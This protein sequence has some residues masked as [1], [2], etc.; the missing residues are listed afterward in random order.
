VTPLGIVDTPAHIAN[1][2]A[3]KSASQ[4]YQLATFKYAP[5]VNKI[6]AAAEVSYADARAQPMSSGDAS[7]A[8]AYMNEFRDRAKF[9]KNPNIPRWAQKTRAATFVWTLGA[10]ASSAINALMQVPMIGI[11]ELSGRYGLR[12]AARELGFASRLV[13]NAGN[14]SRH[15]GYGPDGLVVRD[16]TG[17]DYAGSIANYFEVS[18]AGSYR[19][20]TDDAAP[21]ILQNEAIADKIADLD[22]LVEMMATNGMLTHSQSQEMLGVNDLRDWIGTVNKYAGL[23]MHFAER[24][25][26]QTMAVAAYTL[27]IATIRD[28]G[29]T[30]TATQKRN[31]ALKAVETTEMVN[32]SIGAASAPRAFQSG[33]GSVVGLYKRFG[34]S[35]AR[36]ITNSVMGSLA[37]ID[38]SAP[39]EQ[40]ENARKE[41]AIA[42]YQLAGMMG[43]TMLLSGVQG[44]PFF[45]EIMALL[46][47]LFTGDDE[48]KF[49]TLVAK[50]VQEPFYH[51][52]LNYITGWEMATRISLSG[53]V[54]RPMM[55]DKDQSAFYN[56]IETFG[57]PTVGVALGLERG[58]KLFAQ[59]EG[60]RAME[61]LS[62]AALRSAL[63][64]YRYATEGAR[65][66]RL[67]EVTPV[68]AWEVAGQAIG[69]SPAVYSRQQAAVSGERKIREAITREKGQ[70]YRRYYLALRE[71][72]YADRAKIIA[73]LKAFAKRH[74]QANV[75][76]EN[77]QQSMKGYAARSETMV[78]GVSFSKRDLPYVKQGISEYDPKVTLY[79]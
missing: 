57:G 71:G 24:F 14:H 46:N 3:E 29:S 28:G 56:L 15:L 65:T 51:G 19:L 60:A 8:A 23:P 64:S 11:S 4:V 45:G 41:R 37:A 10:Y 43:A 1:M 6:S 27:E 18:E 22:A 79:R 73:E 76:S 13:L 33:I 52:A 9:T 61:A 16:E 30:P 53:L 34:L 21:K 25:N 54:Y 62:P 44:L 59:G 63:K 39:R 48:E 50:F 7:E 78:S 31:A 40:Q 42:R 69:F 2:H 5:V 72:D 36:Y 38:P 26:R 55:I 32:G 17:L 20:R 75:T 58:V 66:M 70:I 77:L 67:D 68:N 74:P 12:N 47:A 35:M 49:E